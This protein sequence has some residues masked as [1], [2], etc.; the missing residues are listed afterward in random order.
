M[1]TVLLFVAIIVSSTFGLNSFTYP[2]IIHTGDTVTTD[3]WKSNNDT[4]K[5]YADRATDTVNRAVVHFHQSVMNHDSTVRFLK[6]DTLKGKMRID[7]IKGMTRI[8]TM[9]SDSGYFGVGKFNLARIKYAIID[10]MFGD[11]AM[12]SFLGANY[13]TLFTANIDSLHL[14]TLHATFDVG[15]DGRL[16]GILCDVD[17]V[18]ANKVYTG[19]A[20]ADSELVQKSHVLRALIDSLN[21]GYRLYGHYAEIDTIGADYFGC[22]NASI[23]DTLRLG[24]LITT[25][26]SQANISADSIHT[27]AFTADSIQAPI[28][29]F[30]CT[31]YAYYHGLGANKVDSGW[32]YKVGHMAVVHFPYLTLTVVDPPADSFYL[33]INYNNSNHPPPVYQPYPAPPQTGFPIIIY[34]DGSRQPY[35][36]YGYLF[37]NSENNTVAMLGSALRSRKFYGG[38][39]GLLTPIDITYI[40]Q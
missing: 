23:T 18:S 37:L 25:N 40:C 35:D 22:T 39:V 2:W 4:V 21:I 31:L 7:T 38:L 36:F 17:S 15:T 20:Y 8:D 3:K 24:T 12:V 29:F 10:T 26:Y 5:A 32:W 34:L 33:Q 30:A 27:R 11:S 16:F 28:H 19:Y 13:A 6:V 9:K 14:R 1:K